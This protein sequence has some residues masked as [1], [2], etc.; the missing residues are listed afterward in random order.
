[1]PGS[2]PDGREP[3]YRT[4]SV[5]VPVYNER[6]TVAEIVRRMRRVDLPVDLEIILV[7][8]GS[9][10]GT[11][12][13]VAALEDSTVCLVR[14]PTNRGKGSAVR[15]GVA[16]ARGDLVLIQDADLEYDPDEWPKLLRPVLKGRAEVVYGT[17]FRG[18][19]QSMD[20]LNW[21][22][23]RFLTLATNVL[24]NTSLSDMECGYKL[25]DRTVLDGITIESN[26]FGFE[27]EITAKVLRSGRTIYEVPVS[28]A[29]RTS[30]E[31]R[32]FSWSDGVRAVGTLLRHRFRR[33]G[34]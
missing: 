4:L 25:F 29:G 18:E 28:Y 21:L 23:N 10:D 1:M 13:I 9:T 12:K 6:N 20:V 2:E 17:R 27:P 34:T 33:V 31:G 19:R 24:Y 15:T 14:H 16:Q 32:K 22:G 26:G 7:D 8:D 3:S 5:V 30:G 11:E